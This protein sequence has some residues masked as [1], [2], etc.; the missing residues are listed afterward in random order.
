MAAAVPS[1]RSVLVAQPVAQPA[2]RDIHLARISVCLSEET[3]VATAPFA[4]PVQRVMEAVDVPL[5]EPEAEAEAAVV[6]N[7][8]QLKQ[9]A[10]TSVCL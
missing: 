2:T 10:T 8:S 1:A 3:A 4:D 9:L 5:A 7:A 6:V